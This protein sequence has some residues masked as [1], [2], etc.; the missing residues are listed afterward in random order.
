MKT[1][2]VVIE[3]VETGDLSVKGFK[4]ERGARLYFQNYLNTEDN[5][6]YKVFS[7]DS[8]EGRFLIRVVSCNLFAKMLGVLL[9]DF[10]FMRKVKNQ[11]HKNDY[12]NGYILSALERQNG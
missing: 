7:D 4:T 9:N 5:S 11:N 8:K 2:Q 6:F 12:P 10:D 3:N 1:W